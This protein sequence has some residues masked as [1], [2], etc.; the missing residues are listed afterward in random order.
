MSIALIPVWHD[1]QSGMNACVEGRPHV[2]RGHRLIVQRAP[3]SAGELRPR[4]RPI[5]DAVARMLGLSAGAHL[6]TGDR[7]LSPCTET[8]FV[9]PFLGPILGVGPG[10]ASVP[11]LSSW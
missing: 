4:L 11:L 10:R 5:G 8:R 9:E 3:P 7:A 1:C 6:R 2:L